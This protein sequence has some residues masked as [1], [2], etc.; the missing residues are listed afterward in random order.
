VSEHYLSVSLTDP[1]RP[2]E[3]MRR[4]RER[5]PYAVHLEWD[6]DGGSEER[7]MRYAQA[8]KGRSDGELAANFVTD[9]RAAEPSS[10]ERA[11]L[12]EAFYRVG[13]VG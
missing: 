12:D 3:A 6:P 1:V 10:A 5:F 2:L 4:L 7:T 11:L 8:V 13:E 9:C